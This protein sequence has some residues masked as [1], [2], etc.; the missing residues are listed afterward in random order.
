EAP[1]GVML[2]VTN[3]GPSK[4]TVDLGRQDEAGSDPVEVFAD[5]VYP[6]VGPDLADIEVAGYGYRWIRLRR[7]IGARAGSAR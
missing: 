5:R 6:A 7:T 1:S 4:R 2:A 3:L